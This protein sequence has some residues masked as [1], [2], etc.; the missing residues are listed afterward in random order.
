[1]S[2]PVR[3]H[4]GTVL[5]LVARLES[6]FQPGTQPQRLGRGGGRPC[7]GRHP[8]PVC[9]KRLTTVLSYSWPK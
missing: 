9:K 7:V 6:S 3:V 8:N 1:M 2:S 4:K 5:G